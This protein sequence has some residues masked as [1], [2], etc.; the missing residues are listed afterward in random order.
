[1]IAENGSI[2]RRPSRGVWA[3]LAATL[4]ALFV[5]EDSFAQS[6]VWKTGPEFQKQVAQSTGVTWKGNPFRRALN[7]LAETQQIA[8]LLDR[9]VDPERKIDF[10]ASDISLRSVFDAI[11]KQ[12]QLGV[13]SIGPVVYF[14]PVES[15]QKLPTLAALR[16]DDFTKLTEEQR[17]RFSQ[18]RPASWDELSTPREI[19]EKACLDYGL[20]WH[21]IDAI[22]HDLWPAASLPPLDLADRLTLVLAG[23]DLTFE[24]SPNGAFIRAVPM[25]EKVSVTRSYPAGKQAESFHKQLTAKFAKL[26]IRI[27]GSNL[28]VDGTIEEHAMIAALLR[29]ESVSRATPVGPPGSKKVYSLKIDNKPVGDVL[30]ALGMKIPFDLEFAPEVGDKLTQVIS[31]EVREATLERLLRAACEPA[32]F[33]FTLDG[34]SV[35]IIPA[36]K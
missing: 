32:G 5:A 9:R 20:R 22:P 15:T 2:H 28:V 18:P 14:G 4:A 27:E 1:M 24:I 34:K 10:A 36:K 7:R 19:L 21:Q 17:R 16:R 11:G 35:K 31:F 12:E 3:A 33:D 8:V 13:N 30:K 26:P 29:G 23:F 25:P 6:I